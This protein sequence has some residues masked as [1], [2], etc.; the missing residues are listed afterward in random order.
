MSRHPKP[1]PKVFLLALMAAIAPV[2]AAAQECAMKLSEFSDAAMAYA[3]DV[4]TLSDRLTEMF[5][6]F[7]MIEAASAATPE[8]CP[9]GL[10]DS[11]TAALALEWEPL[12]ARSDA[13]LDCGQFFNRRILAD[14]GQARSEND[15]QLILRLGAVQERI[16]RVEETVL[17]AATQA[18]FAG[19]RAKALVA[20]HDALA[21]RCQ[22]LEDIYD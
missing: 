21:N 17:D 8:G 12:N 15:G 1:M 3:G 14:I 22:I 11:R 6:T 19:L 13:L 16:F 7:A 18:T 9:A 2:G 4:E 20:E 5:P 10:D